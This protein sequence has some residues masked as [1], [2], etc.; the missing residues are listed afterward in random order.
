[1]SLIWR[2]KMSTGLAWQDEQHKQIFKKLDELLEA[3]QQN[4]GA[5]VVKELLEFLKT[6][7]S[8]HFEDEEEYM[9]THNCTTC[10]KHK[11]CHSD[12][13]EHLAEIVELYDS[14][15]ASTMVVLRLQTWLRDWLIQHIMNID[16]LMAATS[17]PDPPGL[18]KEWKPKN[19]FTDPEPVVCV[20]PEN[21]EVAKTDE[22]A[23]Q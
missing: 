16:K 17:T 23:P 18:D 12:F 20:A 2:E 8:K 4:R 13:K 6:Y 9:L 5:S 15:G 1:M 11:E 14:Q 7:S 22:P 10:I 21:N 3:M 19:S